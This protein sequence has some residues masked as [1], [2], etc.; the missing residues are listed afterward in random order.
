M[1]PTP[2]Q[3][4]NSPDVSQHM[5]WKTMYN[6]LNLGL[7]SR[8]QMVRA[9]S[10]KGLGSTLMHPKKV[11]VEELERYTLCQPRKITGRARH[12]GRVCKGISLKG[13]RETIKPGWLCL[14]VSDDNFCQV[15]NILPF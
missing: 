7:S 10:L 6:S 12:K 4:L 15:P 13:G 9:M 11:R 8:N 3:F 2:A 14:I 1:V 5:S